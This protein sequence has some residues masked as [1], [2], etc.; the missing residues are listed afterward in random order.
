M[1][2]VLLVIYSSIYLVPN[3]FATTY[4]LTFCYWCSSAS[5]SKIHA[6]YKFTRLFVCFT[7]GSLVIC[8][9][10][11]SIIN[12]KYDAIIRKL[13]KT[14]EQ[15]IK[16]DIFISNLA[17]RSG[18]KRTLVTHKNTTQ[19]Q[20]ESFHFHERNLG[21][22]TSCKCFSEGNS[23]WTNVSGRNKNTTAIIMTSNCHLETGYVHFQ[24]LPAKG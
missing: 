13:C 3:S 24:L 2:P 11:S 23:P 10:I 4:W 1:L 15:I 16:A 7:R 17:V 14:A 21:Q 8:K 22:D 18:F 19:L 12:Y 20:T 5:S 6:S 9:C